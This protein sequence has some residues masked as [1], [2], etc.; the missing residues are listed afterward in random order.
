MFY[1]TINV[2]DK[3]LI[4][5]LKEAS[6][7]PNTQFA[8]DRQQI[9]SLTLGVIWPSSHVERFVERPIE[10]LG[11]IGEPSVLL[12]QLHRQWEKSGFQPNPEPAK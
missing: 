7:S 9:P 6:D 3:T 4:L 5:M 12:S 11:T 10:E 2:L 1:F 8:K